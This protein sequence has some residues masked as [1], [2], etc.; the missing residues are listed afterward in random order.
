MVGLYKIIS[1]SGKVYIGQSW[2]LE[3]RFGYY[4]RL[5]CRTQR[6][7]YR[8]F[9]KYGVDNHKIE[10][11]V[12]LP[13]DITQEVLNQY[14][15]VYWE[16]Y[17]TAGCEMLNIAVPGSHKMSEETKVILSDKLKGEK[18][19]MYGKNMSGTNNPAFGSKKSEIWK[20]EHSKRISKSILQIDL[21]GNV[22]REW[23]SATIAAKKLGFSQGNIQQV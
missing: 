3:K 16:A 12:N 6:K 9:R 19:P 13:V 14:E 11:I 17:R 8:S 7:L 2:D 5:D 18:N 22:I 10:V 15:Q 21:Q 1:P 23:R 20:E 4:H